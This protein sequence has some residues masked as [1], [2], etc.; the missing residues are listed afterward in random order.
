MALL[1]PR[2]SSN[3]LD[4]RAVGHVRTGFRAKHTP[5]S[6]NA[7]T[8]DVEDYFQVEAFAKLVDRSRWDDYPS[9]VSRNTEQLLV[10]LAEAGAVAAFFTLGCVWERRHYLINRIVE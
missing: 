8:I 1:E 2:T 9:R 5:E 10:L 6:P 3:M 7:L 4:E